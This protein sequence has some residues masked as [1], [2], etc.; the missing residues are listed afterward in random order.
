MTTTGPFQRGVQTPDLSWYRQWYCQ[1]P[2]YVTS[3]RPPNNFLFYVV[4]QTKRE[5]AGNSTTSNNSSLYG[6]LSSQSDIDGC[7]SIATNRA[8]SRFT[9]KINETAMMLV[10]VGERRHTFDSIA[11]SANRLTFAFQ[12]LSSGRRHSAM[13]ALGLKPSGK[14]WSRPR[15]ASGLFLEW[16]FGWEPL[17]ADIHAA[18]EILQ[19]DVEPMLVRG[20]GNAKAR[21]FKSTAPYVWSQDMNISCAVKMQAVVRV[22]NPNLHKASQLGL[23]NPAAVAWELMPWSFLVD[24]FIPVGKF[25]D[26]WS[27][28]QG[29]EMENSFTTTFMKGS[30]AQIYKQPGY[31]DLKSA[32]NGVSCKRVL[33]VT[34]PRIVWSP[35]SRLSAIRGA[36]AIAL[37]LTTFGKHL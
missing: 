8:Y 1:K 30:D 21:K 26:S 35:P 11:K 15:D 36:T 29:L 23:T 33:G 17:L 19:S 16:H 7:K 6:T 27:D 9:D 20:S 22:T 13:K 18:C 14:K 10:N 5:G 4:R 3:G 12:L 24:W 25:L 37:L 28:F 32:Y 2:P 31:W 34:T